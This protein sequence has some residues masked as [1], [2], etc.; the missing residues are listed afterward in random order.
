MVFAPG[1][2]ATYRRG[3]GAAGMGVADLAVKNSTNLRAARAGSTIQEVE[4]F[5]RLLL[6]IER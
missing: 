3:V 2:E 6:D 1:E 4:E 5:L